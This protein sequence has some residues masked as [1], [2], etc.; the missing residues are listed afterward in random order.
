MKDFAAIDFETSNGRHSSACSL[1]IV[2]A[3]CCYDMEN[4]HQ[5]LADAAACAAITLK[6]V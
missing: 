6:I 5:A 3:A 2:A 1:G 4:H